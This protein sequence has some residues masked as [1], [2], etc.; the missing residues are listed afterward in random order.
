M[1]TELFHCGNQK[2]DRNQFDLDVSVLL[3]ILITST[4]CSLVIKIHQL[5]LKCTFFFNC[6]ALKHLLLLSIYFEVLM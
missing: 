2:S 1:N 6:S 5:K 3:L 4:D